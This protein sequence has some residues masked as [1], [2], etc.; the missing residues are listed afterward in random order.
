[1]VSDRTTV[2]LNYLLNDGEIDFGEFDGDLGGGIL[3]IQATVKF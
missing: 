1:M 2:W 3:S